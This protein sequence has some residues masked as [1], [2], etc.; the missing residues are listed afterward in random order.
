MQPLTSRERE[1]NAR[2]LAQLSLNPSE[3]QHY[4]SRSDAGALAP[5]EVVDVPEDAAVL[6]GKPFLHRSVIF[7]REFVVYEGSPFGFPFTL[8]NQGVFVPARGSYKP[9]D[10]ECE[11]VRMHQR[12]AQLPEWDYESE[13]FPV[14]RALAIF[15]QYVEV[16]AAPHHLAYSHFPAEALNLPIECAALLQAY[17]AALLTALSMPI[18]TPHDMG[19]F[20]ARIVTEADAQVLALGYAKATAAWVYRLVGSWL[21]D[22]YEACSEQMPDA[23]R[24]AVGAFLQQA[25]AIGAGVTH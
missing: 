14:D 23:H 16:E 3:Y 6:V 15:T 21:T 12:W 18:V 4:L 20:L 22:C 11:L 10:L 1:R 7:G 13:A 19:L 2:L 17:R 8:S 5:T 25:L 24:A 9:V